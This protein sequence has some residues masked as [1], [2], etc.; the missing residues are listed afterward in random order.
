MA[1]SD[2][3]LAAGRRLA[4]DLRAI[5]RKHGV[6]LKEVL[7]ATRLADDVIEALE[8]D[9]LVNHPAFNRVYLK[10]LFGAYGNA[11]GIRREDMAVALDEVFEGNYIGSLA[12][13][14]LG[15]VVEEDD[16]DAIMSARESSGPESSIDPPGGL[17]DDIAES[18]DA[19][20]DVDVE[21]GEEE[22]A[23]ANASHSEFDSDGSSRKGVDQDESE[24]ESE[25]STLHMEEAEVDS[26]DRKIIRP[27]AVPATGKENVWTGLADKKTVLLPNMS[28]T[29]LMVIAGIAFVSL[30]WF[31]IS[32]VMSF[33]ADDESDVVAPD[34]TVMEDVFRPERVLL[35][36]SMEISVIAFTE[37]LDPIRITADRDLRKPYWVELMDTH[38]V[39]VTERILLEREAD[40]TR[41]LVDGFAI[42]QNWLME[43]DPAEISRDRVQAWLDSLVTAGI[44]PRR[45]TRPA[46]G[47]G[48][49]Q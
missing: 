41:V 45:E 35:P 2:S 28:G 17:E 21:N 15:Q 12:R 18:E 42:P 23:P 47:S 33:R 36:D 11:V 31:A 10:S 40:H 30:L 39:V 25:S 5:R 27:E 32:T 49:L 14:Y 9:A 22:S 46:S 13:S 19:K 37:T 38:R 6:D 24:P 34:T 44:A 20:L 8:E 3:Q 1:A 29:A 16:V 7:D 48:E 4:G 43:Q 26:A